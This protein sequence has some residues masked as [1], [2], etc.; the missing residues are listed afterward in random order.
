M[1]SKKFNSRRFRW[2]VIAGVM[3]LAAVALAQTASEKPN[4]DVRRVG[5]R[6]AC[7]CGCK[8]SVATCAMLECERS[9]PAKERIAKMQ[10]LGYSDKQIV[11]AFVREFGPSIYLAEPNAWGWIVPYASVG[12]GLVIIW[13]FIKKYRKPKPLAEIGPMEMDDPALEKYKDQI[14]RDLANME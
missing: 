5:A 11:D 2:S 12:L 9:K 14:E 8:D 10:T 3:V 1:P 13:L 4:L 7:T 6:L